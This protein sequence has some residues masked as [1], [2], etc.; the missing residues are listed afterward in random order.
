MR[1]VVVLPA[2]LGPMQTER[3]AVRNG[4]AYV[5]NGR[6]FAEVFADAFDFKHFRRGIGR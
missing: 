2:P 5:T 1:I 4:K 3:Q 6:D